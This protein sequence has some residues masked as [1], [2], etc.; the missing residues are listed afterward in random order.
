MS[1]LGEAREGVFPT[2]LREQRVAPGIY[3]RRMPDGVGRLLP[4]RHILHGAGI[5]VVVAVIA[6]IILVRMWPQII[7]WIESRRR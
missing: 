3:D 7:A 1:V 6:A 5:V 2:A 4:F